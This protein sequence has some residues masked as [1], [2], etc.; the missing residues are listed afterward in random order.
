MGDKESMMTTDPVCGM[1]VAP[2]RS[3]A[4]AHY[5]DQTYFFCSAHCA[6]AFEPEPLDAAQHPAEP[7]VRVHLQHARRAP[8]FGLQ[9]SP[10]IAA[11]AMSFSSLS[12][13]GKALRLN[14]MRL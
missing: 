12:V 9:L 3:A 10:I 14:R 5:W 11:A 8:Y 13:V 7:A 6:N 2:G 4:R 1:G